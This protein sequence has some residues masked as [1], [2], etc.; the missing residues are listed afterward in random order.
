MHKERILHQ[1]VLKGY[2]LQN[3]DIIDAFDQVF[4]DPQHPL[5][6]ILLFHVCDN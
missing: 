1:I 5:Q 3:K 6:K 4:S 2:E